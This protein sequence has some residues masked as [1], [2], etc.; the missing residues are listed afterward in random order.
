MGKSIPDTTNLLPGNLILLIFRVLVG[1]MLYFESAALTEARST[2]VSILRV[3]HHSRACLTSKR[4]TFY[5]EHTTSLNLSEVHEPE[6]DRFWPK[7]LRMWERREIPVERLS[8]W[9]G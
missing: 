8:K 3:T 2:D 1:Y 6:E 5:V 4:T 7:T 9:A